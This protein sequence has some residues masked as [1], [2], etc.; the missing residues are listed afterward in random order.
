MRIKISTRVKQDFK[1]V[2][3]NFD[4]DLFLALKP[5]LVPLKLLRFDGCNTGDE[6]HL[7]LGAGQ[8][9]VSVITQAGQTDTSVYFVDEGKVLPF[10]LRF[11]RH[12]HTISISP[13]NSGTIITDNIEYKSH[14]S[15]L[16]YMLYPILYAQF[17]WRKPVYQRLFGKP[18]A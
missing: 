3:S 2:F 18:D 14:N 6:V 10:F 16:E 17:A 4:K 7:D 1:K 12:E 9:W 5:P 8:Q 15:L 13:N 11:W